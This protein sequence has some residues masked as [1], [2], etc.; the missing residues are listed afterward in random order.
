MESFFLSAATN[1]LAGIAGVLVCLY[2][3]YGC[4]KHVRSGGEPLE[5]FKARSAILQGIFYLA[6]VASSHTLA[7]WGIGFL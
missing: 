6:I 2:I 7:H 3:A 4:V 5:V 1:W